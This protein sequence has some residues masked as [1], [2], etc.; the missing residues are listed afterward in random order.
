[1]DYKAKKHFDAVVHSFSLNQN[2]ASG[3]MGTVNDPEAYNLYQGLID[4]ARGIYFALDDFDSRLSRLEQA[5]A[6]EKPPT[7][8]RR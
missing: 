8:R 4:L 3:P 2:K 6:P 1:M 7:P 5:V